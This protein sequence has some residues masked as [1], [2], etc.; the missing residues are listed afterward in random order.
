MPVRFER[1]MNHWRGSGGIKRDCIGE[2]GREGG[3]LSTNDTSRDRRRGTHSL[4]RHGRY[5]SH[6][7]EFGSKGVGRLDR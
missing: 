5:L 6:E 2:G 3:R 4:L 1:Q 7:R